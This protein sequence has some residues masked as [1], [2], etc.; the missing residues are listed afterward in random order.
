M[1]RL[2]P[3]PDV[4]K[5]PLINSETFE[6]SAADRRRR[7]WSIRLMSSTIFVGSLDFSIVITSIWSYLQSITDITDT[8]FLGWLLAAFGIGQFV[9]APLLGLCSNHLT[10]KWPVIFTLV[11]GVCANI[12]YVYAG[13]FPSKN[14]VVLIVARLFLGIRGGNLAVARSYVSGATALKERTSA[15]ANL[16]TVQTLGL[17]IG[18]VI[19]TAF[20]PV[21]ETGIRWDAIK[22]TLN[23][24]TI[25]AFLGVLL[26]FVTIVLMLVVFKSYRVPDTVDVDNNGNTNI[27]EVDGEV[28]KLAALASI[29]AFFVFMFALSNIETIAVPLTMTMYAWTRKEAVLYSGIILSAG[30]ILAIVMFRV[31]NVLSKRYDERNVWVVG[32]IL[33]LF[34]CIFLTPMPWTSDYP[35]R[36]EYLV[37]TTNFDLIPTDCGADGCGC[38]FDWCTSTHKI[39]LSQYLVAITFVFVGYPVSIVMNFTIF[40]KI[41]GPKPQGLYMGFIT[42]AGSLARILGPIFAGQ[43]YANFGPTWTFFGVSSALIVTLILIAVTYSRLIPFVD[44]QRHMLELSRLKS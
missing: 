21:G 10:A 2:L 24:Y 39:Y 44:R 20:T 1:D 5:K 16:A 28:D 33:F 41:L 32:V 26:G 11:L 27:D 35:P 38:Y 15:M 8:A 14:G 23:M 3:S 29:F 22:L 42:A 30:A 34:G 31:A 37:N 25:P 43:F 12:L 6:E 17:M 4:Q 40:S 7:W 36:P 9:S 13:A 19:Q 18:P